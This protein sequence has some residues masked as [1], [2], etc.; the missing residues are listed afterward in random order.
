MS[1]NDLYDC[2]AGMAERRQKAERRA[3]RRR[4]PWLWNYFH[5]NYDGPDQ[6]PERIV[7]EKRKKQR[8]AP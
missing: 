3:K 6:T 8:R 2:G 7:A 5:A 4:D 1:A